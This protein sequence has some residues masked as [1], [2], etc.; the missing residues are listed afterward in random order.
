MQ[1]IGRREV[2]RC[3]PQTPAFLLNKKAPS[4][5]VNELD[6]RGS[7]YYLASY[8][9]KALAEQDDD[10]ELSAQFASV[11]QALADQEASIVAELLAAQGE[12]VD[13]G[14]YYD[15]NEERASNAMRPSDTFN[16]IIDGL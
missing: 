9:A 6:N 12:P 7:Q 15:P 10:A 8:W 11:A 1:G 16:S 13:I 4:R 5:K 2:I 3:P 14:G